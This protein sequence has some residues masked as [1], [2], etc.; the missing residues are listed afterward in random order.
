MTR[1]RRTFTPEFKLQLVK[2]YENGKSRADIAR[3]YD[4]TPSALDRWIK[5]YLESGSFAAKDNRTEEENELAR[6]RKEN[7]RLLMEN[8][9]LKQAAL[10]MGRKLNVIRNN[11]HKYSVSAMCDV[12]NIPKSTYYYHADERNECAKKAEDKE[13]SREIMRIFKES[14]N[15]YGTRKIKKVL[16]K[17][18]KAKQVSRRRIGRLMNEMGLV[19]N[20]TVA[21]F[22]PH[23]STCNETPVKNELQRQFTQEA[24]L[25]VI[26][27]DLTYVR[28]GKKWHYVCLFVDLFNREIIGH[29]AG[30]NKT[31]ELVYQ[32]IA[33]IQANLNDVKMF[34]TDRG[35]EFDNKLIS[36]ALD[37]FGIKRSLSMK[38]CPYDNAVA[39]ATFKVFK[40]EFANGAHFSSLEQ[41]ALELNDYVHWFNNI[42]IHG[43]LAYLTPAEFKQQPL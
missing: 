10:I 37:T 13:L 3:E 30:V 35:K 21:Q 19:S 43:T 33:S 11:S 5:N 25:A 9:I 24:P 42:R 39:E 38:G 34:H 20:Y 32:A 1:Q 14:R 28:V 41:L 4:I 15:N 31:A 36:T 18:P 22:K 7:Q 23:R 26:V 40:T 16:A 27:S 8:D 6:L 17:L 12:L 2:L 29:S